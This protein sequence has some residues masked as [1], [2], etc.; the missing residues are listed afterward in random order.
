MPYPYGTWVRRWIQYPTAI[1][2]TRPGRQYEKVESK[3]V[4]IDLGS[5]EALEAGTRKA[6]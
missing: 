6:E 1:R 5:I 3:F 4:D 2:H